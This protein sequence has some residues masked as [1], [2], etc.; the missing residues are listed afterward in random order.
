MAYLL[1]Y[2]TYK[3]TLNGND[4]NVLKICGNWI[5]LISFGMDYPLL[6]KY[7]NMKNFCIKKLHAEYLPHLQSLLT[8]SSI[9]NL[10]S[11]KV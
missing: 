7:G 3:E 11:Y 6:Y 4:K 1:K 8:T 5:G 10:I 9:H 2:M